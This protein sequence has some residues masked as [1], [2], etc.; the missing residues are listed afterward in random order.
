MKGA[1]RAVLLLDYLWLVIVFL[2]LI[3][4][5]IPVIPGVVTIDTPG[6]DGWT[7]TI[8]N[9][10]VV[11]TGNV[12]I[13][14]GGFFPFNNFYFVI[15][16]F[17]AN[18]TDLASF[19]SEKMNLLPGLWMD[20]PV[21]FFVDKTNISDSVLQALFR[22]EVTFGS[23]IYFNTNYLFDFR[24]QAGFKGNVTVGP[25]IKDFNVDW[26]N[27]SLKTNGTMYEVDIPYSF[28]SRNILNG[29][30]MSITGSISNA[31]GMLGSLS[32]NVTLGG[33]VSGVFVVQLSQD[34]YNHLSTSPDHLILDIHAVI[35]GSTYDFT[36]EHDW[37]P[38]DQRGG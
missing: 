5:A 38:P 33:S 30:E 2:I 13:R 12:S 24:I 29:T 11:T 1:V 3:L 28:T 15:K 17:D 10:T 16:L 37:V 26:N 14:N 7:T 36:V 31:T 34:A 27:S 32:T 9:D 4:A 20:V 23:I 25:L 8:T 22:S 35:N 18:G 21:T 6:P 19:S